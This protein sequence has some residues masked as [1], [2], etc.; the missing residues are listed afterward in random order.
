MPPKMSN[1]LTE[2]EWKIM[3]VIWEQKICASRDVVEAT[4]KNE[5]WAAS[6]VKNLLRRLVD[7]GYLKTTQVGNCFVYRPAQ[8][9]QSQLRKTADN[10]LDIAKEGTMGPIIAYMVRNSKLTSAEIMELHH[11]LDQVDPKT[12]E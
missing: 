12:E 3:K 7:K 6:T 11:L 1:K 8:S 4:Q 9:V 2:A 5:G 10:L